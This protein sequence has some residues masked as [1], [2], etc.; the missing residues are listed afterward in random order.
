MNSLSKS[1]KT[2]S[3]LEKMESLKNLN[4]GKSRDITDLLDTTIKDAIYSTK[5]L[6]KIEEEIEEKFQIGVL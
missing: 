5:W 6:T 3:Y 2:Q 1:V 4:N